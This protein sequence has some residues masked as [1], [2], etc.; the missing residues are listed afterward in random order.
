MFD[1]RKSYASFRLAR[2]LK[3]LQFGK[4]P[5]KDIIQ[6]SALQGSHRAKPTD[7][8]Y[9]PF[10][11]TWL[12]TSIAKFASVRFVRNRARKVGGYGQGWII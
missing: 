3:V 1:C 7:T 10:D 5:C 2:D 6:I 4:V 11:A 9:I 12:F 8:N